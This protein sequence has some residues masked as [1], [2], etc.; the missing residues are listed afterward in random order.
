MS[1]PCQ[2]PEEAKWEG[3]GPTEALIRPSL[4]PLLV[5]RYLF[6]VHPVLRDSHSDLLHCSPILQNRMRS[7]KTTH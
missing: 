4:V 2:P 1:T 3:A 5:C 7:S 6:C